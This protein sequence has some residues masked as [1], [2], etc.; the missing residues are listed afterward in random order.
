MAA[1]PTTAAAKKYQT[2]IRTTKYQP[3]HIKRCFEIY[4]WK[5]IQVFSC[6][7]TKNTV[8]SSNISGR[9]LLEEHY[10]FLKPIIKKG[11]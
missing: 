11:L 2:T 6:E 9:L 8:F 7:N 10:I 4:T 1:P 3:V 5:D